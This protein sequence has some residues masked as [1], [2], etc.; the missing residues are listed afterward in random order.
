MPEFTPLH[1]S[2]DNFIKSILSDRSAAIAFIETFL[3]ATVVGL[4]DLGS[5]TYDTTTFIST[6]MAERFADLLLDVRIKQ[7]EE[8]VKIAVL[9]ELKSHRDKH[10]AFQLLEYIALAYR[11]QIK[12]KQKLKLIIPLIYYH[13]KSKWTPDSIHNF[14][15]NFPP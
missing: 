7:S 11:R 4:L 5:L 9:V 15:K 10:T 6:E 3:P 8:S 13:G 12:Q 2:H 1:I 14:F